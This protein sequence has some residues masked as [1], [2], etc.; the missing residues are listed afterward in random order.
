MAGA[1]RSVA[2]PASSGFR[3]VRITKHCPLHTACVPSFRAPTALL[4]VSALLTACGG[5]SAPTFVAVPATTPAPIT[6]VP[7]PAPT[8]VSLHSV[9]GSVSFP[10]I[11]SQSLPGAPAIDWSLPHVP[12][13]VL[14][15]SGLS[16]LGVKPISALRRVPVDL[17]DETY[18]DQLSQ[19]GYVV[20]PD[21]LYQPLNVSNDPAV[22][23]NAGLGSNRLHQDY[24]SRTHAMDA[25]SALLTSGH[26]P[27]SAVIADLDTGIQLDHPEFA[28]RLLPGYDTCSALDSSM[29]CVGEDTDPSEIADPEAGHGTGTM[30]IIGADGNN[31]AGLAGMSWSGQTL[32]P[33]K[34]FG[35]NGVSNT[36]TS[37]SVAR[38]IDLAVQKGARVINMSLGFV[39]NGDPLIHG[40]LQRAADAGVISV[41]SAGN[42]TTDGVY[43]PASD[44]NVISV[45][46]TGDTD[47]L[48]CYSA[49]PTAGQRPLDLVAPGGNAGSGT[50]SCNTSTGTQILLLSPGSSYSL[51][52]GTSFSAPQVS[53]AAALILGRYPALSRAQ[54]IAALLGSARSVSGGKMLDVAAALIAAGTAAA[55]PAPTPAP[56]PS[57]APPLSYHLIVTA[58]QNGKTIGVSDVTGTAP[59]GTTRVPYIISGLTGSVTLKAQLSEGA[60]TFTGSRVSTVQDM[61]LSGQDIAAQ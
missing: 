28:G 55:T 49:R 18:A 14:V 36:A 52:A 53:G 3:P 5:T 51:G 20:Q 33:I 39:G 31:A 8:P 61:D 17:S 59:A 35:S 41:A 47:D 19:A 40:A 50:V 12:G 9:S 26:Q 48:A 54:V 7:A 29:G 2:R 25:W 22:P 58:S 10:A 57:P 4:L 56:A 16:T 13:R 32:L 6:A 42:T 38:G 45:G 24:L 23:G 11:T 60:S 15:T 27:V 1:E 43:Y 44:P 21:Y 34:V 30:G 46:A 37:S